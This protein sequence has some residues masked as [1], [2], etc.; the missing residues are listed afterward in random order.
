MNVK[1]Y[2]VYF[3]CIKETYKG[4]GD[5]FDNIPQAARWLK[6]YINN[7]TTIEAKLIND[8]RLKW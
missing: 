3:M 5:A 6:S 8:R 7:S 4:I 1:F 2:E